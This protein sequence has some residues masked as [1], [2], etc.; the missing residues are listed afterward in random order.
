MPTYEYTC[1]QCGAE[2]TRIMSLKEYEAGDI[3]C[4]KCKS[5]EVKQQMSSFTPKTSRKS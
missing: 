3:T 2:F 1:I 5:T 4:P